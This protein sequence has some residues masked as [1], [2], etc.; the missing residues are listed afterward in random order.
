MTGTGSAPVHLMID[1]AEV[2]NSDISYTYTE[3]PTV[4]GIDPN[5]TILK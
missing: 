5:W 4:T 2:T 1:R 3:D